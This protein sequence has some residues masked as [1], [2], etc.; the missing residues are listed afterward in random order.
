M[1]CITCSQHNLNIKTSNA[2]EIDILQLLIYHIENKFTN[3]TFNDENDCT[4]LLSKIMIH[5]T[6][7]KTK[8]LTKKILANEYKKRLKNKTVKQSSYFE[9]LFFKISN[10]ELC[11]SVPSRALDSC[12]FEC[13]FCPTSKKDD[14]M[15][16][17]KS[18]TIGQAVFRRLV[19]N[20]NNLIKYLLDLMLSYYDNSYDL[21]KLTMRHLG[22]TFSTYPK[23]YRYEYCRDIFY[24][25]NILHLIIEN[26]ELLDSAIKLITTNN[27]FDPDNL[28]I[29]QLRKPFNDDA[30][31][32]IQ[33]KIEENKIWGD[34]FVN[35]IKKLEDELII[36]LEKSLELEQEYN[37][38]APN[39]IVGLSIETRPDTINKTSLTELLKLG[40]TIIELGLQST[41][42]Q[43]LEINKRGHTIE[44]SER[45]ILLVKDNGFHIHGQFMMD[46][47]GSTKEID[48]ECINNILISEKLKCDQIKIYPHLVMPGTLTA[49]WLSNRIYNSWVDDDKEGFYEVITEFVS[50]IDETVRIN[51][52]QRDLPQS[53]ND[54]EGYTNDQPSNLEEI[55][56]K[57][58]ISSNK[59][60]EDISYHEPGLRIA[61]I[62]DIK[63]YVNIN[64]SYGGTDIF[65]SAQ[66]Y[67]CNDIKKNVKD[68]RIIWG[69]CRLRLVDDNEDTRLIKFFKNN[70]YKYGRIREL[71]VNGA[72]QSFGKNSKSVQHR[73]IGSKLLKLAEEIAHR[74]NMTH[75]TVTSAVGVRDYYRKKHDYELDDCGLMWK[76]IDTLQLTNFKLKQITDTKFEVDNNI[77]NKYYYR[78]III[79]FLAL[80][81]IIYIIIC[82]IM[83][84][85]ILRN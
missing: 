48:S 47:P 13:A 8:S 43:I 68:F 46:L 57:K 79:C 84:Y 31:I 85:N 58:I 69:Y 24:C 10:G 52:I 74:H 26:E 78:K 12:P 76:K 28:I 27:E 59:N 37:V 83:I 67:V 66:S 55:V 17:A 15:S 36:E 35:E 65:I 50:K 80:Y 63:Y 49:E 77:N 22:G 4:N 2:S 51:R 1:S 34:K 38:T 61:N 70:D 21:S 18:Y 41:N 60:R 6:P 20:K 54:S 19:K 25:V 44:D 11:I 73:G 14:K 72:V 33:E 7:K 71:K 29:N 9:K 39:K 81:S 82:L 45:A 32:L 62:D 75:V 53:K 56:T 23:I 40:V 30:I 64:K 42:N 5:C 3:E 16:I